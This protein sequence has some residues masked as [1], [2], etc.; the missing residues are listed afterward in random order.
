MGPTRWARNSNTVTAPKSPPPPRSAQNRVRVLVGAGA[1]DPAVG[2]DDLG[3]LQR[4]DRQTVMAHEPA[5]AAAEREPAD[6]R[7]RDLTGR[8]R[9]SVLLRGRVELAKQG[10]ATDA[11]DR[12]R[13]VV[14]EEQVEE[15]DCERA[16]AQGQARAGRVA[17]PR[18]AAGRGCGRRAGGR[19]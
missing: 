13:V 19:G 15:P 12:E 10:A 7:V 4:V 1:H 16:Q 6:T 3:G 14:G 9:E 18:H 5:D 17:L 2:Q 8:N 11:H